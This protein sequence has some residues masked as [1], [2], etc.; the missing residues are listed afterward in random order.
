[1]KEYEKNERVGK[2]ESLET[3]PEASECRS[4]DQTQSERARERESERGR[5]RAREAEKNEK[6][7]VNAYVTVCCLYI[8]KRERVLFFLQPHWLGTFLLFSVNTT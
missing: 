6:E 7:I 1:M 8:Q 2:D 5:A 4:S 3:I